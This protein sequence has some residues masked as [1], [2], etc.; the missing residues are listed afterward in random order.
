MAVQSYLPERAGSAVAGAAFHTDEDAV[1]AI[2]ALHDI[3]LRW[4]DVSVLAADAERAA[5]VARLADAWTPRRAKL[6]LPFRDR[7]P[8]SIRSRYGRAVDAGAIV[9]IAASNDQPEETIAA[10]LEGAKGAEVMTWWQEPAGI[11]PPPELG[12]PL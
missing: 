7:L 4:Q 1:A 11:F 9:V 12:G 3:G 8:K 10:V 6:G 2:R 5:T